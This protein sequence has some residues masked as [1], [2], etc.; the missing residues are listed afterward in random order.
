ML[1]T[2]LWLTLQNLPLLSRPKQSQLLHLKV[3]LW[4]N[5]SSSL[6]LCVCSFFFFFCRLCVVSFGGRS[7]LC[8]IWVMRGYEWALKNTNGSRSTH[9][10][11]PL[12]EKNAHPFNGEMPDIWQRGSKIDAIKTVI[13]LRCVVGERSLSAFVCCCCIAFGLFI[14]VKGIWS[15]GG[16]DQSTLHAR[17]ENMKIRRWNPVG[18]RLSSDYESSSRMSVFIHREHPHNLLGN[19]NIHS[20]PSLIPLLLLPAR[21][22]SQ[23]AKSQTR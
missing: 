18:L 12:L 11:F 14:A 19:W 16:L 1:L 3:L 9:L 13:T 8:T 21:P 23:R 5:R 7:H 4:C 20:W 22:P 17:S 15:V 6:V 2:P 10:R